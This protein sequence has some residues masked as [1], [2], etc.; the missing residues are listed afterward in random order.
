MTTAKINSVMDIAFDGRMLIELRMGWKPM[1]PKCKKTPGRRSSAGDAVFHPRGPD[2]VLD[3]RP[4]WCA[5]VRG[6]VFWLPA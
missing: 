5:R 1:P 6:E 3:V 4:A 2:M